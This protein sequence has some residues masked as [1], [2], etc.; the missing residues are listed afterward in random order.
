MFSNSNNNSNKRNREDGQISKENY[1]IQSETTTIY[2]NQISTFKRAS[3]EE[4]LSRKLVSA[5]GKY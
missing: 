3:E 1:N 5:T 4:I 2:D